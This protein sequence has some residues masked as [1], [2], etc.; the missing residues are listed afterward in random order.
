MGL[1]N[2]VLL[3]LAGAA[4]V[5]LLLHLLQR[6]QG[7]RIVFP[8][9]RYLRR[10]EKES[11]RRIRLR[12]ILLMLLRVAA[13]LL[14]AFAA[15]RPFVRAGGVG[16]APTAA[17]LILDNSMST[18]AIE[19]EQRV[20]EALQARALEVLEQAGPDDRF[21]LLRAGSPDE[22]ALS[23][24]A[25]ETARRVRETE[26]AA[27]AA[28]LT[29]A[30]A[31]ARS[32]LAAGAE[33]RATE[34]Q[35]LTDL[36]ATS[37]PAPNRA[38]GAVPPVIVWH[39]GTEPP[40]NRFVAAVEVGGGLAP[41][42]EQRSTVAAEVGGEGDAVN[43]RL[44]VDGRLV[45]AATARPGA[46]AVLALPARPAGVVSGRIEVDA[47]ALHAD[48]T[49]YFAARVLPPPAVASSTATPF[50]EDA[51]EVLASAGRIRRAGAGAGDVALL[52]A[53]TGLEALGARTAAVVLPPATPVE[54][55]AVNRRL[56]S[57]GIPWRFQPPVGGE[58]RFA[59]AAGDPLLHTLGDTRLRVVYPLT[60][61]G[62][63]PGDSV[64]IRLADGTPWAVRGERR[65]GGTYVV[66]ASPLTPEAS[67]LPTSAAMLPL[68]DRVIGAWA[69]ALP[70]RSTADAGAEIMLPAAV[71]AVVRA[72]G[73]RDTVTGGSAYRLP[74]DPGV[75]TML[76]GDSVA[77]AVAVNAPAAES[78]LTRLDRRGLEARLPGWTLHV[79]DD[80]GSW[81]RAVFRERLGSE[82]WRPLLAAALAVLLLETIVAAAGRVRRADAAAAAAAQVEAH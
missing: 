8:A 32:L 24:D 9:L 66:L 69:L 76:Q 25:Q 38:T 48:D 16:H 82:L 79:A 41:I 2:P 34:I 78:D 74:L 70:P 7:P 57:A 62:A 44:N 49:R 18:A 39:P 11:A 71:T 80:A 81:R 26:P 33:A 67:T 20:I 4:V 73:T 75:Y 13:V 45:A 37:F 14:V 60:P 35:L 56:A 50:V 31:H 27:T 43:V 17:V 12:Q 19:G 30:L 46:T 51:L 59:D 22:P 65:V 10:A 6:H 28:D 36:Q 52:P 64:L 55:P 1:L 40:P 68:L 61:E 3:V 21:W 58:A 63:G 29:S 23:G 42:A 47:D 15:A 53:A 5:P 54:V 77:L 72:D